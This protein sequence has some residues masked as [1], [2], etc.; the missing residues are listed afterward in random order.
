MN[1]ERILNFARAHKIVAALVGAALIFLLYQFA[2]GVVSGVR[3][4]LTS[5]EVSKT[6]AAAQ[7]AER[8]AATAISE[9]DAAAVDRKVE[10]G[11][12]E[13]TI[14]PEIERTLRVVTHARSR[15]EEAQKNYE[16]AQNISVVGTDDAALYAS[17]CAEYARLYPGR[18][19][20]G[21]R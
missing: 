16:Q 20:A 10:D 7:A 18:R 1:R 19:R 4:A 6:E 14:K 8:E 15:T 11:I 2:G 5:R 13:R 3:G 17:N 12:R 21:C 9:A